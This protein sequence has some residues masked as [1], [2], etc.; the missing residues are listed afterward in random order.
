MNTLMKE[1]FVS[2]IYFTHIKDNFGQAECRKIKT[3]ENIKVFFRVN[4]FIAV[5]DVDSSASKCFFHLTSL[6]L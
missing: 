1:E 5:S 3:G 4:L 2:Q 6:R